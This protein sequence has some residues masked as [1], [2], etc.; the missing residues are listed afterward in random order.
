[1]LIEKELYPVVVRAIKKYFKDKG[2]RASSWITADRLSEEVLEKVK[3]K[4][5]C[6]F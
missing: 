4:K 6:C 3:K 2:F 5:W 1:M